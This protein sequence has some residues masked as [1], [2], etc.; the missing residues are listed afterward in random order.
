MR[1]AVLGTGIMG[2]GMA[3]SLQRSG[4]EVSAWNRTRERAEPL[5]A[6]GIRITDAVQD[7]VSGADVVLTMVFGIDSVLAVCP[8]VTAALGT[9]S[10]WVQCSTVGPQGMA[11]LAEAAAGVPVLDAPV[12]GT[13]QPAEEGK[14]IALVSG[15]DPLVER[16]RPVLDAI[17][18]RTVL[19]G[20]RL[21][22]AS[23][24]KL[25]CNAWVATL[26][27]ATAQSLALAAALGVEPARFLEAIAGSPTDSPYAQ[28]KGPAML[29][30]NWTT[31]FA[32][33][34]V[35]KDV[36]LMREAGADAGF[37]T[38]LLDV[39]RELFARAAK[40]GHGGDDMA[41]VHAAFSS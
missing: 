20:P 23:A 33:D 36:D 4:I 2:A 34:G 30:G 26:T 9:D 22:Q 27:A 25:A 7:A 18:G 6:D 15:P 3:R 29:A 28:V 31:S 40:A 1:A 37:P 19:V 17:A 12:L 38:D 24:L 41:A 39:V 8:A 32:V 10:V 11:Q 13:K 5:A 35:I 16:V 14:L 21:G